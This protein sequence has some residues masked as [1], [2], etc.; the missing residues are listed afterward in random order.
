V[1]PFVVDRVDPALRSA[2]AIASISYEWRR[3]SAGT[4]QL[5]TPEQLQVFLA[6]A[7]GGVLIQRGPQ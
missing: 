3:H 7:E 4:W 1:L 5:A 2:C 6:P